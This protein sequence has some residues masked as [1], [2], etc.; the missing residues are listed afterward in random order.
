VGLS[1]Y[2]GFTGKEREAS[3]RRVHKLWDSGEVPR[4]TKCLAC[5]QEVGVIHGHSEDYSDDKV[6]IPICIM[7]HLL[8][9]M[10]FQ[11]PQV[12]DDYRLAVR[13][14]F[15]YQGKPLEQRNALYVLKNLVPGVIYEDEHYVGTVTSGTVLD[16]ICPIKFQHPNARPA[17]P[18]AAV[19]GCSP[20]SKSNPFAR[21]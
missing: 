21:P 8:L 1:S 15:R 7:C 16:M 17:P 2:N 19:N 14:G 10:R 9:H 11:M 4:P 18:A 6:H 3:L 20:R 12:W 5:A 13:N